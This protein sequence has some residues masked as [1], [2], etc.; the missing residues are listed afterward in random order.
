MIVGKANLLKQLKWF[1][2]KKSLETGC[3]I[4][5]IMQRAVYLS[6]MM[7]KPSRGANGTSLEWD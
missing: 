5:V 4:S 6:K 3:L 1:V 7:V 2:R